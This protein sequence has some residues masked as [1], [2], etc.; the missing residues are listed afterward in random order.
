M[1]PVSKGQ[2]IKYEKI[3]ELDG[4]ESILQTRPSSIKLEIGDIFPDTSFSV[5]G[6]VSLEAFELLATGT[7]LTAGAPRHH[8]LKSPATKRHLRFILIRSPM[9]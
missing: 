4:T 3:L 1:L 7:K 9:F 5:S 6:A 8:F 2:V